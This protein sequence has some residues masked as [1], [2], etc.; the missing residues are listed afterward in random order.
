MRPMKE[1]TYNALKN[2]SMV[3]PNRFGYDIEVEGYTEGYSEIEQKLENNTGQARA[4]DFVVRRDGKVLIAYLSGNSLYLKLVDSEEEFNTVPNLLTGGTLFK[5]FEQ[6]NLAQC[7]SMIRLNNGKILLLVNDIGS[8][9]GSPWTINAYISE[10]GGIEDFVLKKTLFS[11]ARISSNTSYA[12]ARVSK[13]AVHADGTV[14][15]AASERISASSIDMTNATVFSSD[16]EFETF[17]RKTVPFETSYRNVY[18]NNFRNMVVIGDFVFFHYL[19]EASSYNVYIIYS[20]NKGETWSVMTHSFLADTYTAQR[21]FVADDTGVLFMLVSGGSANTANSRLYR[22]KETSTLSPAALND[23]ANWELLRSDMIIWWSDNPG[24]LSMAA[25]GSIHWYS[26][27][28]VNDNTGSAVN[29]VLTR[30]RKAPVFDIQSIAI[31]KSKG[32]ANTA[33]ISVNNQAGRVNPRNPDSPLYKI[34]NLNRKAHIA[35]GYGT[36]LVPSFTGII[37]GVHMSTFPMVAE[38]KLRDNLKR[39]L[40]QIVTKNGSQVVTYARQPIEDIVSDLCFLCGMPVGTIEP[41]GISVE[42]EFNWQ[43]YADALQFLSDIASFEFLV[44]EAGLFHFRRDYQP[45]DMEVA[46]SFE[47]GVDIQN[48]SYEIDDTDLYRAVRVYGKSE[49]DQVM[50]YNAAFVDAEEFN[51][52][53]QKIM[54]IDATETSTMGELAKIAQ[55]ALAT[56]RSRTRIIKFS[57]V[58]IPHLQVGDFIQLFESSTNT[59]EIYR[60]SS[61]DLNMTKD[62]FTMTCTAYYYGDSLVPDELPSDIAYQVPDPNLNLI[63]EMTSNTTPYGVARSSSVYKDWQTTYSPWRA[64]NTD[65][66]DWFWDLNTKTGWIEYEFPL[67]HIVDKYS[68]KARQDLT[69]NKALPKNFTFEAFDGSKWIVLDTRTNQTNWGIYEVRT[70]KFVNTTPYAKYRLRVSAN[71]GYVRTQLEQIMMYYGGGA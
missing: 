40:D 1:S 21:T 10:S 71:N 30:S 47:E 48:L 50:V 4:V 57:A 28:A 65:D 7:F 68:L 14:F 36:D 45:D 52:L 22:M 70:F 61:I 59:H 15:F 42:K 27:R 58:A 19:Y 3:G 9:G 56:M 32:G 34:L 23:S 33:S 44:D 60:L 17:Q 2:R 49:D 54:K 26:V 37:D 16:S 12:K 11:Q 51:I 64:M 8:F 43:T 55:R 63:P 46:W 67:K 29:T 35:Q 31:S 24:Y 13:P 38:I 41:T 62:H 66:D 53:P 25:D 39:A 20:A 6:I 5:T 18:P 69:W